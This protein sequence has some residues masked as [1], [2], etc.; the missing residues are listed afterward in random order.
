MIK[1]SQ[2]LQSEADSLKSI[3]EQIARIATDNKAFPGGKP[4]SCVVKKSGKFSRLEG[5]S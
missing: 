4:P 3:D 1:L 5:K 2:F